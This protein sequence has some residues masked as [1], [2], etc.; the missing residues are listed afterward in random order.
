MFLIQTPDRRCPFYHEMRL[1]DRH[2]ALA[3]TANGKGALSH[4]PLL[5][6]RSLLGTPSREKGS[7]FK[8]SSATF[9]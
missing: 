2:S 7:A 1:G 8:T 6:V 5:W 9:G 4:S 3:N